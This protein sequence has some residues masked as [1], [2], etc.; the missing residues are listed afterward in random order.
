MTG[1]V[2]VAGDGGVVRGPL[3]RLKAP[4]SF[5]GGVDPVRGTVSDPRHPDYG[6]SLAGQV[7]AVPSAVGS[8]SSSAIMLEL[9][10]EGTAPRALLLGRADAIVALGV[11]VARELGLPA[12]PVLEVP[13][14]EVA[15]LAEGAEVVV[16]GGAVRVSGS[17]PDGD[18]ARG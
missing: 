9:I 17:G 3:L 13:W 18:P 14:G 8:S 11:V 12:L 1:R 16:D 10:R 7:V 5:W 15:D 6:R 2:L 4:L